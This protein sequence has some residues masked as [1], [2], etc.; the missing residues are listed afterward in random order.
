[1]AEKAPLRFSY[2]G[3]SPSAISEFQSGDTLALSSISYFAGS[4]TSGIVSGEATNSSG[5][6][7]AG[8]GQWLSPSDAGLL[9]IVED[10]TPQLGGDLDLNGKNIDFPTTAN[11]SD[12]L[13]EDNM[14]SNSNVKLATQQSIKAYADT[15]LANLVEDLTPE[16]RGNLDASG[17][18]ITGVNTLSVSGD[19]TNLS[20]RTFDEYTGA[21]FQA[22]NVGCTVTNTTEV[23]ATWAAT[24]HKDTAV[25]THT[26][27]EAGVTIL[28][29]GTYRVSLNVLWRKNSTAT[30]PDYVY[31]QLKIN[32]TALNPYKVYHTF[33]IAGGGVNNDYSSK[34]ASWIVDFAAND[35]VAIDAKMGA[36]TGSYVLVDAGT[37]WNMEKLS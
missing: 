17:Y 26:N 37:S 10:T 35:V 33:D 30:G 21:L 15:K 9:N 4:G 28:K 13:D 11:I 22:S 16:L 3:S 29:A 19:K 8:D 5:L 32:D 34:C 27:T 1:V 14:A 31:T 12:C 20:G 24:S 18:N 36:G 7:L 25:Y 2:D 23:S 6:F